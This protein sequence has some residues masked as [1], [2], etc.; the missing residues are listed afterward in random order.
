MATG[1]RDARLNFRLPSDLKEVIEEAAASLGQSV[2]DFAVGT[3][4]EHARSVVERN[5][6]TVLSGRD[7]DRFMAILD[8]ADARPNAALVKAAE[9]YRKRLG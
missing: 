8:D 2:S 1:S 4:V 9:R 3:L 6:A 7:R 5:H